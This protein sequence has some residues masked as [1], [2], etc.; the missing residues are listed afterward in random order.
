MFGKRKVEKPKSPLGV[1]LYE[2]DLIIKNE[3]KDILDSI[4]RKKI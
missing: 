4:N 3:L 2:Y 1:V